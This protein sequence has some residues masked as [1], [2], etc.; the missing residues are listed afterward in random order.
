MSTPPA[1][2]PPP[3]L[4]RITGGGSLP[5]G[6]AAAYLTFL[7]DGRK[8][9]LLPDGDVTDPAYD[10]GRGIFTGTGNG[11]PWASPWRPDLTWHIASQ[12]RGQCRRGQGQQLAALAA[13]AAPRGPIIEVGP[14]LGL[15]TV[16]MGWGARPATPLAALYCVDTFRGPPH[17][18]WRTSIRPEFEANMVYAGLRDHVTAIES[19]SVLAATAWDG[20]RPAMIYIDGLHS[21]AAARA[22]YQAWSAHCLPGAIIAFDDCLDSY[23][24]VMRLQRE[25]AATPGITLLGRT[26][27]MLYWQLAG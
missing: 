13:Q 24:G 17:N 22:D 25:L 10:Y 19:P 27:A 9:W 16:W 5:S 2:E 26:D 21:Y 12:V 6:T 7:P 4:G 18:P 14:G 15:S 11:Q 23:P 3:G 8:R 20:E 1:V